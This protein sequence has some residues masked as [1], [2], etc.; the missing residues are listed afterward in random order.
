[1][2]VCMYDVCMFVFVY[3]EKYRG[4]M[5]TI[6]RTLVHNRLVYLHI[7][8]FMVFRMYTYIYIRT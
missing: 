2:Y 3:A 4:T 6:L 1:M 7:Q 8:V 5:F